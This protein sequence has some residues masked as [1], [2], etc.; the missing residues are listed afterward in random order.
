VVGSIIGKTLMIVVSGLLL[1]SGVHVE[2][3]KRKDR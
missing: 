2:N 3:L 1:D